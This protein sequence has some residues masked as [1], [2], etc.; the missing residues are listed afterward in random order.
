M[1]NRP[2][3]GRGDAIPNHHLFSNLMESRKN[4]VLNG[5]LDRTNGGHGGHAYDVSVCSDH[6]HAY[7]V[8]GHV[9]AYGRSD[10]HHIY[11]HRDGICSV[12][13]YDDHGVCCHGHH[14]WTCNASLRD[15]CRARC[16]CRVWH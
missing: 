8:H 13:S 15:D 10:D 3:F 1:S 14:A 9:R 6:S 16:H 5:S 4:S 2:A 7:C 11:V 12:F